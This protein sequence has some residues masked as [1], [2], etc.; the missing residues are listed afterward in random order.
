M[1]P[2][3]SQSKPHRRVS[4][5]T[6]PVLSEPNAQSQQHARSSS[7]AASP[8]LLSQGS[9]SRGTHAPRT[10]DPRGSLEGRQNSS[11][12]QPR[13]PRRE[14]I[15]RMSRIPSLEP[16]R[17]SQRPASGPSDQKK[18]PRPLRTRDILKNPRL[19]E[20]TGLLPRKLNLLG[21]V[22]IPPDELYRLAWAMT[23]PE[24]FPSKRPR[25]N[26]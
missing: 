16:E 8:S 12:L 15:E 3:T 24:P 4:S 22:E 7:F 9:K 2:F 23:L 18:P 5:A 1:P 13:R 21:D 19:Q 10:Y 14:D 25:G 11:L 20:V 17:H 6:A 26:F